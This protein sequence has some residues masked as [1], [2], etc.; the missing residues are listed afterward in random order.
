MQN[1]GPESHYIGD[2]WS[3][4][5]S[6]PAPAKYS[7]Q[8]TNPHQAWQP[9]IT[10]FINAF[11]SGGTAS[12]MV[13]PSDTPVGAMWYKGILQ[14]AT[15]PES[16]PS[17]FDTGTDAINWAVVLP[18]GSS[19]MQIRATS[20]GNE[21][22]TVDGKPGLNMGAPGGVQAGEQRLEVLD[23]G[24]NVVLVATN[25]RCVSSGCPDGVYDF[26]YQVVGLQAAGVATGCFS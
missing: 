20:N 8:D 18:A 3:E 6:D 19:G 9:I 26:N 10:S 1:D 17:G 7:G 23:A 14:S 11:K 25:G 2:L 15:C 24:G 12:T 21:L 5:N 4:E 22:A 13:P 16:K